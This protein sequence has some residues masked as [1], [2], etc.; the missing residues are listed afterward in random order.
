MAAQNPNSSAN[1]S[2]FWINGLCNNVLAKSTP[3]DMGTQKYWR[4]GLAGVP[5]SGD[6]GLL[7]PSGYQKVQVIWMS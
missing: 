5:G 6:A 7:P 2:K 4:N 1:S 3:N